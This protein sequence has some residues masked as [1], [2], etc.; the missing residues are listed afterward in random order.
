MTHEQN[1]S[2]P[3][4]EIGLVEQDGC[5]FFVPAKKSVLS[6]NA[7]KSSSGLGFPKTDLDLEASSTLKVPEMEENL[8]IKESER[9]TTVQGQTYLTLRS[10][11]VA[12]QAAW[13]PEQQPD[14]SFRG[15]ELAG[16]TGE[17]CNVIKK[18]E[19][20]RQGWRGSRDTKEHLAEELAD[21]VICADLIGIAAGIDLEAAVA[22]KFN[23]TSEKVGLPHRLAP[24]AEPQQPKSA[25]ASSFSQTEGG[26]NALNLQMAITDL[27]LIVNM[28]MARMRKEW[29]AD[30]DRQFREWAQNRARDTIAKIESLQPPQAASDGEE[31]KKQSL[32][33][34]GGA[35]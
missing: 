26:R 20:E 34:Q 21:V 11:N 3:L 8:G 30:A 22:L 6:E 1:Q 15:N 16:E 2:S 23:A 4:P 9:A 31:H 7:P 28:D 29:G 35:S 25:S 19:R 24:S 10:A 27:Y 18:L 33:E 13:C 14:L 32:G 17:V 12:R 5:G